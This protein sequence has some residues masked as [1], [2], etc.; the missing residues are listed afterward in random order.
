MRILTA[1]LTGAVLAVVA[2]LAIIPRASAAEPRTPRPVQQVVDG[3][4][5]SLVVQVNR[6]TYICI[7]TRLPLSLP[8][9]TIPPEYSC[10]VAP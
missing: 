3:L 5:K 4:Y 2:M 6:Q 10:Q 7:L 8:G 1:I 9:Y